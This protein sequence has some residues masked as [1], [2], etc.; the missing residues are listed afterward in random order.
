[1]VCGVFAVGLLDHHDAGVVRDRNPGAS[2]QAALRPTWWRIVPMERTSSWFAPATR[3]SSSTRAKLPLRCR[4]STS[5]LASS[6][7]RRRGP[8]W[9]AWSAVGCGEKAGHSKEGAKGVLKRETGSGH[10]CPLRRRA[11]I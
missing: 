9:R 6:I 1:M 5:R 10:W 3:P 7:S 4:P 2:R 11:V 8:E